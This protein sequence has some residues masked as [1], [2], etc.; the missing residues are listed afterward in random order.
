MGLL[1]ALAATYA[2]SGI[3][4]AEGAPLGDTG[5][6]NAAG[7]EELHMPKPSG[8]RVTHRVDAPHLRVQRFAVTVEDGALETV[9]FEW[10][11][12]PLAHPD[13]IEFVDRFAQSARGSCSSLAN[14]GVFAGE[15]N[16]YPTV[17]RLLICPKLNA[18]D[19][20]ELMM[21]KAVRGDHGFWL[22]VRS[23][24]LPTPGTGGTPGEAS[25]ASTVPTEIVARWAEFMRAIQI[26][27]AHDDAHPCP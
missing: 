3:A 24:P 15:E 9:R 21:V 14:R 27:N 23:R 11:E 4:S 1:L 13:P 6:G 19:A 22:A 16:G 8:W 5:A 7:G 2:C 18:R 26:C 12:P 17:V 20:G 25:T 10:F